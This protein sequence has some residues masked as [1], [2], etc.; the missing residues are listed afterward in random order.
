M[1]GWQL[2]ALKAGHMGRLQVPPLVTKR[3]STFLNGIQA[4]QGAQYGYDKSQPGRAACT[5]IGLLSRMALGWEKNNP[6]LQRGANWLG[7]RGPSDRN[8]Y[9][10][11]YAT[12][13][14]WHTGGD[15]WTRWNL[16]VRDRL[17]SLQETEGPEKGSWFFQE[18]FSGEG[19]R[20]MCTAMAAMILETYYRYPRIY[21]D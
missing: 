18:G 9:Y 1:F 7:Q 12:Q 16:A 20:L 6:A 15:A 19:G 10:T 2:A 14:M 17:I 11:Y 5:A 4:D 13:V 8:I 3:A 21:Q